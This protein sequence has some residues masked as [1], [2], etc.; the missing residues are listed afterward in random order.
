VAFS[1]ITVHVQEPRPDAP[2]T[3]HLPWWETPL[4]QAFLQSVD[5]VTTTLRAMAVGVAFALPYVLVFGV[6]I[7]GAGLLYRQRSG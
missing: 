5:G 4:V 1:T 2:V 6:P 3:Q 7:V